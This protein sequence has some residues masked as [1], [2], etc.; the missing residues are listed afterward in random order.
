MNKK[1]Y[2]IC[3]VILLI[4]ILF[5]SCARP[6]YLKDRNFKPAEFEYKMDTDL[7]ELVYKTLERA[8][9]TK[10]DIPDYQLH[11]RK[12]RIFVSSQYQDSITNF[13]NMKDWNNS[14]SHLKPEEVPHS[15]RNVE[16]AL[17]NKEYLQKV[18][19]K[20]WEDFLY[21]SFRLIKIEED[22]ATIKIDNRWIVSKHTKNLIHMSGGGYLCTYKKIDGI[23]VFQ[24][25]TSQWIS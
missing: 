18:S 15:I 21:A 10:K 7:K 2:Y 13:T 5:T 12:H 16:F 9:V 8:F 11:W 14:S 4:C 3:A 20:T 25:I 19:D 22:I 1:S 17:K 6:F 24:K 23:W